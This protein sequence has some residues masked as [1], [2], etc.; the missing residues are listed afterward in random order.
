MPDQKHSPISWDRHTINLG[1]RQ[2]QTYVILTGAM[3]V[4]V[5]LVLAANTTGSDR[6]RCIDK[7][8][9][10]PQGEAATDPSRAG[11]LQLVD[12]TT[13]SDCYPN[14]WV[15]YWFGALIC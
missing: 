1:D 5:S 8:P 10:R 12:C 14:L 2:P 6:T 15:V 9:Q 3:R 13:R 11:A 4:R 7:D